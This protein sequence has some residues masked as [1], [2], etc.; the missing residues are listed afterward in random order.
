MAHEVESMVYVGE[1]PWHGL[2]TKIPEGK[3]LS[4]DE[5]ITA[6]GLDS[7]MVFTQSTAKRCCAGI[8]SN[9]RAIPEAVQ[10]IN[11]SHRSY[12]IRKPCL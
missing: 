7:Y 3:E 10:K 4:I 12:K 11:Q 6:A 2:G 9:R 8:S 5:A 1:T